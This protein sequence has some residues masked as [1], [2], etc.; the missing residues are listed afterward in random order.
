MY[1]IFVNGRL[2]YSPAL[3]E[4][5]YVV[6]NPK[7]TLELGKS[8]SLTF[9]IP[10]VNP[11]YDSIQKL[12][13]IITVFDGAEEIFRG[14]VLHDEKDFLN[15]KEVYCEGELAFL[16]DSIQRP[17]EFTGD[18]PD[19][20]A[21]FINSHNEQVE[22]EKRFLVGEVTVT[23]PNN[24][25]NRSNVHYLNTW[26]EIGDKLISTHG[27]YL[28]PR[29]TNG[30]RYMDLVTVYGKMNSQRIEFGKNMLDISEYITAENVFTVLI[31]LGADQSDES[32]NSLGRLTIASVNDGKDYI[33]DDAAISLFGR[34]V[35]TYEW[36]D[37]TLA[38]NLYNKGRAF[39]DASIEMAVTL[40]LNAVDL[41]L[42]N[43][44]I[45]RIGLGD[46]VW[47][48]SAP[49]KLNRAFLCSKIVLDLVNPDNSEYTLGVTYTTMTEQQADGTKIIQSTVSSVQTAANVANQAS[50]DVQ[51]VVTN[52]DKTYVK[53]E[54]YKADMTQKGIFKLLTNNGKVQGLILDEATGD[55][56]I[57][58]SYIKSGTLTIGGLNSESSKL[59]ILDGA[60]EVCVEAGVDGIKVIKGEINATSGSLESVTIVDGIAISRK[61]ADGAQNLSLVSIT[62][63]DNGAG[64]AYCITFGDATTR[65]TPVAIEGSSIA[66]RANSGI[67]FSADNIIFENT[68]EAPTAYFDDIHVAN[69]V[70]FDID[71][72]E[73]QI[74]FK[75]KTSSGTYQH[76]SKIYGGNAGS[77]VALAAYDYMNK[78]RIFAYDDVAAQLVTDVTKIFLGSGTDAQKNLYFQNTESAKYQH[79][80]KLYGGEGDSTTG[81]GIH[82]IKNTRDVWV[83]DDVDNLV[84]SD[85][86]LFYRTPSITVD[87]GA[88]DVSNQSVDY[89]FLRMINLHTRFT[90]ADIPANTIMTVGTI[91]SEYSVNGFAG[92]LSVYTVGTVCAAYITVDGAIKIKAP[93][94]IAAGSKVYIDGCWIY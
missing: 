66:I 74:H 23:D 49:H 75:T 42:A 32:G 92:A 6:L 46:Y 56:Y 35:K 39:L 30:K 26:D 54:V 52:M 22:E 69:A 13:S 82:D 4:K 79:N 47:V 31:P 62:E 11:M 21:K 5:G 18:I 76:N 90:T 28:R 7:L 86:R 94:A 53:N 8:G 59:E 12:K 72:A 81:I 70:H 58:A 68:I 24:Y 19:L 91:N 48:I 51:H 93:N 33:E 88:T 3:A 34:I 85:S 77:K 80:C 14:R 57:N 27:G 45:E 61:G 63:F 36:D 40:T 84:R 71:N 67:T 15:R 2:L 44:N 37:V 20:F 41:H 29:L 87:Q 89:P 73:K 65:S 1:T 50:K 10:P 83:Y 55:V 16:L 78:L 43:P 25:I 9:F 38:D 60:G 64:T 17:Y